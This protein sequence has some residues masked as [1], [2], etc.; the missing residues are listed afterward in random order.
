MT[1]TDLAS[2]RDGSSYPSARPSS[3]EEIARSVARARSAQP[4][5]SALG[6][7][8]RSQMC[9]RFAHH[10]LERRA[11]VIDL[12]VQETGRSPTECLMADGIAV[13]VDYA[14]AAIR[15]ARRALAP[16]RVR[17][18]PIDW[19]GKKI[20][21]E[22]VPRGVVGII[23]PWNYPFG[24]FIKSLFPALLAGNGV[25]LKPSEYAP[26]TGAWIHEQCADLFPEGLVGLAEGG[27]EAGEALIDAGVDAI[28]FTGSVRTGRKVAA[29]AGERLIPCSLELGGKDA[30]I[31]LADCDLERTVAGIAQWGFH[32]AGQNCAAIERVYVE[33]RIADMFVSGIGR[34]A[35]RLRVAG[36]AEAFDMGPIQNEAQ[37]AIVEAHVEDAR[38]RGAIVVAGGERTHRGLG[39]RPTVLD[40]CTQEMRIVRE[41]TFGP[42]LPVI[43]VQDAEA[44]ITLANDSTYGLNGSVWTRDL[45]RGEAIARRLDV[46]VALV[47]NHAITGA[48]AE[49]PWTGVKDTGPGVAASRHS[50]PTFVRRRSVLTDRAKQ[51]DPFWYPADDDLARFGQAVVE[52]ALGSTRAFVRLAGLATARMRTVRAFAKEALKPD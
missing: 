32:N 15:A 39:Y 37:L 38:A 23:A 44:A 49:V 10:V 41:E 27:A 8:W 51:P 30:A 43:R 5:W 35:G 25:V 52:R 4:G 3:R 9:R 20:V 11:E 31:V 46:G 22:A 18:S 34:L 21:V 42:V 28:V 36:D 12:L 29:R 33:D 50:Y 26:R 2:I 13:I 6:F 47:N 17:L 7:D 19:P 48:L 45:A 1:R 24:N 16:E 40:R 14:K